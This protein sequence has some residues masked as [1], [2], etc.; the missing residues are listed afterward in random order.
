MKSPEQQSPQAPDSEASNDPKAGGIPKRSQHAVA[1]TMTTLE[2]GGCVRDTTILTSSLISSLRERQ[3]WPMDIFLTLA[4]HKPRPFPLTK[5]QLMACVCRQLLT[6]HPSLCVEI[7][8]LLAD[9]RNALDS[10]NIAWVETTLW[11][12]LVALLGG[13][14]LGQP[15]LIVHQPAEPDFASPFLQLIADL[16]GLVQT[17]EISVKILVVRNVTSCPGTTPDASTCINPNTTRGGAPFSSSTVCHVQQDA[18]RVIIRKMIDPGDADVLKALGMDYDACFERLDPERAQVLSRKDGMEIL[19][20]STDLGAMRYL[21]AVLEQHSFLSLQSVRK[22]L[23]SAISQDVVTAI[24]NL[25]PKSVESVVRTGILWITHALRPL[26][27]AE[28]ATALGMGADDVVGD[29]VSTITVSEFERLLCGLVEV[30][31]GTVYLASSLL[32]QHLLQQTSGHTKDSSHFLGLKPAYSPDIALSCR[33]YIL[34]HYR[35]GQPE[36]T[37]EESEGG[38]AKLRAFLM[39]LP[40]TW[41]P[42]NWTRG[43]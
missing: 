26:T 35:S 30:E 20:A 42:G 8:P 33:R 27:C 6:G 24:L 7:Q 36:Q 39:M 34:H 21:F 29:S 31:D 2:I 5:A 43:P 15:F 3:S 11:T 10:H 22:S 28:F 16:A 4:H 1:R 13:Q 38:L 41:R 25:V 14:V 18:N 9:A 32:T 17:T 37:S 23:F 19:A 12:C 40:V